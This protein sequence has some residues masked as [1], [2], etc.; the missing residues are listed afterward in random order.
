MRRTLQ[1]IAC[2]TAVWLGAP[3][4]VTAD[5]IAITSGLFT[6]TSPFEGGP[7]T[8]AGTDGTRMFSFVGAIS[9]IDIGPS[10][11]HPCLSSIGIDVNAPG[12]ADGTLTY[13]SETYRTGLGFLDTEGTLGLFIDGERILL[14]PPLATGEI[15]SFSAPFT[16]SGR[17]VPPE[18]PGG[19][20]MNTL[21][22]SGI[23]TITL[24]GGPGGDVNHLVWDFRTAEYRFTESGGPAP[25]PE[26]ATFMLFASGLSA[27]ALKRRKRAIGPSLMPNGGCSSI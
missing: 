9:D 7:L 13:G 11:C 4:T 19:G 6:V 20:L 22:G 5:P 16:A 3:P 14:P 25:V 10:S 18:I 1:L 2:A 15:R 26:P 27:L 24:S 23:A 12:A 17:L 21:T 8:L